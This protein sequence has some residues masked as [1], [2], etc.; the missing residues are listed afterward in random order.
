MSLTPGT[1]L[2]PYKI[3]ERA[4]AGGMGEVYRAE[5]TRLDRVVA[6]KVLPAQLAEREDLRQRFEREA[7][8]VSSLNHP[9]ICALYDV[10]QHDGVHFLVMEYLEGETLKGPLPLDKLQRYAVEIADALDHAHRKGFTHRDLKPANIMIT[11]AGAKLLDFGLARTSQS[12]ASSGDAAT[13]TRALTTEGSILGTLQYM[14]PEQL[15]GQ[16]ADARS[17]IFAFGAVLYEM[18]TGQMAFGGNTQ[19]S[20]IGSILHTD[21][22]LMASLQ[23]TSPPALERLIRRC[24]A[25][26]SEDRWQSARDILLE[27]RELPTDTAAA[28][29]VAKRAGA[30]PWMLAAAALFVIAAVLG[31]IQLRRA[32]APEQPQVKFQVYPAA[33]TRIDLRS[34]RISPDGRRLVFAASASSEPIRLWVRPL[35]STEALPMHGTDGVAPGSVTWSADSRSI[36]FNA[37]SKLKRVD[38]GGGPPLVLCDAG[39][40]APAWS[41]SG[42]I[43][44]RHANGA[45][46]RVPASGGVPAAVTKLDDSRAETAH[47]GAVFLPDGQRFLYR[48]NSAKPEHAGLYIGALDGSAPQRVK[49]APSGQ[50]RYYAGHL[51]FAREDAVMAQRLDLDKVE[52]VGE[53]FLVSQGALLAGVSASDNG[54]LTFLG[55]DTQD[56]E[57]AVVD[58]SGKKLTAFRPAGGTG[59]GHHVEISP[60]DQRVAVDRQSGA[61]GGIWVIDLARGGATRLTFGSEPEG[62]P[63]WSADGSMI[64]YTSGDRILRVPSSGA[65]KPEVVASEVTH[66][67]H[68]SPDGKLLAFDNSGAGAFLLSL[69]GSKPR[70]MWETAAVEGSPRF[71]PDGRW[72]AYNSNES[73]RSE[74]YVQS[75]PP[76]KGKW[77]VSRDGGSHARWRRDGKE[78]Y[79]MGRGNQMMAA[80]VSTQGG[81]FQA[82]VPKVLFEARMR[83]GAGDTY[84]AV[85]SDGQRFI[86]NMPVGEALPSPITVVLNWTRPNAAAKP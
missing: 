77:L 12:R 67:K 68:A 37:G 61:Q 63:A 35:D 42:V 23:S 19:A 60:D 66:H 31:V 44:F 50:F 78:I 4:G 76:G 75:W 51:F 64:Y 52:L 41:A 24:L 15:A 73:V 43:L 26:D 83:A 10:G 46:H 16:E 6:V 2:G 86:Y 1:L 74:V 54:V 47:V 38:L 84:F 27:L 71:S 39:V 21:P 14:S 18:V 40:G 69:D 48:I 45:L 22:P 80:E 34:V 5:D 13:L 3:L 49:G 8:A 29:S 17:D 70:K 32:P 25:K 11:K 57:L 33:G 30:A 72:I 53:P 81:V 20:V 79:F 58:R 62:T 9:H 82:G 28:A 56:G 65:G 36:A 59:Y 55:S 7:R 85:N